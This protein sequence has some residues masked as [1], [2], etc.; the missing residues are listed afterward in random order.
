MV[1][2]EIIKLEIDLNIVIVFSEGKVEILFLESN[3]CNIKEYEEKKEVENVG[4]Y[5][6]EDVKEDISII[7]KMKLNYEL[8]YGE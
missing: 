3:I 5:L 2:E 4:D 7:I 8:N 1:S 6:E